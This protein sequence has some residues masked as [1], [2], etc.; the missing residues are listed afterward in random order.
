MAKMSLSL[1]SNTSVRS[2]VIFS[3]RATACEAWFSG[4]M[5]AMRRERA[6]ASNA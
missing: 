5:M 3:L 1:S 6:R 4:S 2:S